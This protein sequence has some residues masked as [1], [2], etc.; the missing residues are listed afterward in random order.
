MDLELEFI[1]EFNLLDYEL[2]FDENECEFYVKKDGGWI[3]KKFSKHNKGYLCSGFYFEKNKETK[4][5][6]HRLIFFAYNH[7]FEIFRRSRTENMID[8][9]DGDKSNNRIENL[10]IVTNQQNQFNRKQAKGY[11]WHKKAK[12]WRAQIRINGKNNKYLG[13]FETE[14]EARE[15]YLKA[16]E[17]YHLF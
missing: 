3:L 5:L 12:K 9:V 11:S 4:I 6:K 1:I 10:R 13:F 15:A 2:R 17:M 7:D 8:H 16:K 14:E